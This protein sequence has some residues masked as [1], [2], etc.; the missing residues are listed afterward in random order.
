[1]IVVPILLVIGLAM[2][3]GRIV[4]DA[5]GGELLNRARGRRCRALAPSSAADLGRNAA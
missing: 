4:K 3:A 5:L 2:L 1:M